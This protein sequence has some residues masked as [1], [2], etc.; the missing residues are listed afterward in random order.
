MSAL[1][2]GSTVG[3]RVCYE[4]FHDVLTPLL[5]QLHGSSHHAGKVP[6]R[7]EQKLR[8]QLDLFKEQLKEAIQEERF[9]EAA[10]LRDRISHLRQELNDPQA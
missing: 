5:Q 1:R 6:Q 8:Q 4:T 7:T 9:E 3:C 10:V 2:S